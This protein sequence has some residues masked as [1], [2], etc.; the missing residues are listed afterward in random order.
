MTTQVRSLRPPWEGPC[1]AHN[2]CSEQTWGGT[3]VSGRPAWP[4]AIVSPSVL[5]PPGR[6]GLGGQNPASPHTVLPRARERAFCSLN[7]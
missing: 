4:M 5:G 1:L 6:E 7:E 2:R 3:E